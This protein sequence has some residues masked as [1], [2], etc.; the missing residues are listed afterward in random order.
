MKSISTMIEQLQGL[1]GTSDLNSW[2]AE[3]VANIV[4]RYHQNSKR[5]DFFTAKVVE[6]IERIW[7]KHFAG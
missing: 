6:M 3:F 7:S 2:E 4:K 5:T 1:Q